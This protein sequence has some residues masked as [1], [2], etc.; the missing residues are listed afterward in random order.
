M[1]LI[2]SENSIHIKNFLSHFNLKKKKIVLVLPESDNDC[3]FFWI[4]KASTVVA[5]VTQTL[6]TEIFRLHGTVIT[7]FLLCVDPILP[8]PMKNLYFKQVI[9]AL[10]ERETKEGKKDGREEHM[11]DDLLYR[12]NR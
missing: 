8:Y 11:H 10:Q 7:L 6:P 1:F 9:F 4:T 12:L 3:S 5:L 2:V